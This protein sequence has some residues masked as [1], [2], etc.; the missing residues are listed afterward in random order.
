MIDLKS[1]FAHIVYHKLKIVVMVSFFTIIM[2][3]YSFFLRNSYYYESKFYLNKN[4]SN[5]NSLII[6]NIK[7]NIRKLG[8]KK[9]NSNGIDINVIRARKE[10]FIRIKGY[11]KDRIKLHNRIE[12]KENQ[13]KD[14]IKS[15]L[16]NDFKE[17]NEYIQEVNLKMNENNSKIEKYEKQIEV[18]NEKLLSENSLKEIDNLKKSIN[19]QQI[20]I[21]EIKT[22]YKSMNTPKSFIDKLKIDILTFD[23]LFTNIKTEKNYVNS[24]LKFILMS[25]IYSIIMSITIIFM[26]FKNKEN[27]S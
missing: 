18:L 13:I 25:F 9:L 1:L 12:K 24:K 10:F 16:L 23:S 11:G 20:Q 8:L 3:C 5:I 22:K 19:D 26:F 6:Y 17:F 27:I 4:L 21:E 7:R 15:Q 2:V 14:F